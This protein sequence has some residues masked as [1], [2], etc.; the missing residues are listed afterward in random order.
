[1]TAVKIVLMTPPGDSTHCHSR[2]SLPESKAVPASCQLRPLAASRTLCRSRR[3]SAQ[4]CPD[5][6][7]KL[8]CRALV[9]NILPTSRGLRCPS[10]RANAGDSP[11]KRMIDSQLRCLPV[12]PIGPVCCAANAQQQALSDST[13]YEGAFGEGDGR[14]WKAAGQGPKRVPGSSCLPAPAL[15][16]WQTV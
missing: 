9:E 15:I 4:S 10:A 12:H 2:R 6:A 3:H 13:W 8:W 7:R 1:M 14:N 11:V 5:R 16:A